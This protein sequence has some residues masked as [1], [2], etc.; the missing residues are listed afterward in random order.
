MAQ[1]EIIQVIGPIVDIRFPENEVPQLL[2][3]VKID[4][5]DSGIKLTLE[6]AQIIGNNTVR[7]VA[8]ASTDGLVRGMKALDLG[9][10]IRVAVGPQT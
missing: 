6:V 4:D 1:G 2:N 5:K 3:A 8:L 9:E 10:P 7:T